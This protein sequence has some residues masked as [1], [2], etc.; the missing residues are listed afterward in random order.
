[1]GVHVCVCKIKKGGEWFRDRKKGKKRREREWEREKKRNSTGYVCLPPSQRLGLP[2]FAVDAL[3]WCTCRGLEVYSSPVVCRVRG[4][5]CRST[6]KGLIR[7]SLEHKSTTLNSLACRDHSSSNSHTFQRQR[8]KKWQLRFSSHPAVSSSFFFGKQ[9]ENGVIHVKHSCKLKFFW[10]R[11]FH[12]LIFRNDRTQYNTQHDCK[13]RLGAA[14]IAPEPVRNRFS[15]DQWVFAKKKRKRKK[16]LQRKMLEHMLVFLQWLTL[17]TLL[18]MAQRPEQLSR[19]GALTQ[20]RMSFFFFIYL[21][22]WHTSSCSQVDCTAFRVPGKRQEL[23]SLL[24]CGCALSWLLH[25]RV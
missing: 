8:M 14:A 15:D 18:M 3:N 25:K 4:N 13:Y 17:S 23:P 7:G 1:M 19:V 16:W 10:Q 20:W 24:F 2:E 22:F 11:A 12:V 9:W 21:F 6:N 5:I